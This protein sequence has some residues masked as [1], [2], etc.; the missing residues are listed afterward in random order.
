MYTYIYTLHMLEN[1]KYMRCIM[2]TYIILSIKY[3]RY[4]RY[5]RYIIYILDLLDILD[6]LDMIDIL[7]MLYIHMYDIV[8]ISYNIFR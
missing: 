5:I 4:I 8:H 1:Q 6:I 2:Y 7:H 3:I